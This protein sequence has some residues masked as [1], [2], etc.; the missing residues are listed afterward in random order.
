MA[1]L[2]SEVDLIRYELG[3]SGLTT[4]AEPFI[5]IAAIFD[6]VMVPYLR[7]GLITSSATAVTASAT[8][9]LV[10]IT[11]TA[12]SGTNTQGD[13]VAVHV[14]DRLVVDVDARQEASTVE[15]ISGSIV[16][17]LLSNVHTGTYSVTVE[18][19][20]A[21]LRSILRKCRAAA[22]A[23]EDAM[24]SAGIKKVDEIEFFPSK[25]TGGS[26]IFDDLRTQRQYWRNELYRL[27]FGVGDKSL[28][29]QSSGSGGL[30]SVY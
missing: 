7:S 24:S 16:S 4:G 1:L 22:Q 13:A 8:P 25:M 18:G 20:E 27:L 5:G 29:G 23:L 6:R 26:T 19:S 3:W 2:T 9:A 28:T 11:L 15:S 17:L 10:P 30:V 12:I 14:G 21:L